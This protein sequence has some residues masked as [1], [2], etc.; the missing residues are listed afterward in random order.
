MLQKRIKIPGAEK[1]WLIFSLVMALI[2]GCSSWQASRYTYGWEA[3]KVR[4]AS[5]DTARIMRN[6]S[7]FNLM[8]RPELAL[9]ELEEAHQLDPDNL[10]VSNSLAE[11][12]EHW[13]RTERA[14]QIYLEALSRD[15]DNQVLHNN[16]CFSYY[17]AGNLEQ[18]EACF[19]KTLAQQSNNTNARNNL[20]LV[21][22][23]LGRQEEARQL[24]QAAEG[25]AA[26]DQKLNQALAAL[27]LAGPG[28][29][30]AL[31]A[32][33][34]ST[35]VTGPPETAA[36]VATIQSPAATQPSLMQ[37]ALNRPWQLSEDAPAA[38]GQLAAA[39]PQPAAEA[40]PPRIPG[41]AGQDPATLGGTAT[42]PAPGVAPVQ[43]TAVSEAGAM[44][45]APAVRE[46]QAEA[47]R[48][49]E[50]AA[51]VE[52]T[53]G[54][55]ALTGQPLTCKELVETAIEV[56]NGNG[57]TDLARETRSRLDLEGFTV[58]EIGNHLD[59]GV[60]RT[61][62]YYRP[63]AERV[64]RTL[65]GK[66]FQGAELEAEKKL[67]ED[68]DVKILLGRDLPLRQANAGGREKDKSL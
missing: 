36:P 20:G 26:A 52:K 47:K 18:A 66:F 62:I 59:F 5:G 31:A 21:L 10:K 38:P 65:G 22:C 49:S 58:V 30:P 4:P 17:L 6:V 1:R 13:G 54:K 68:V 12:Y 56:R 60:E 46:P 34:S 40:A 2:M 7:Y 50:P 19:R 55:P 41:A 43:T 48:T 33:Q 23:R 14:Q 28:P 3:L 24:W 35:P 63:G 64:A 39:A 42:Q 11:L 37:A 9:K 51:A 16:L 44:S 57:I 15:S 25:G 67:A 29:A 27:N 53:V 45:P 32:A 8:G 61:V